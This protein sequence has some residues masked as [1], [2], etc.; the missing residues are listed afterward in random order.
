MS[1]RALQARPTLRSIGVN[2]PHSLM[3]TAPR[4]GVATDAEAE[5]LFGVLLKD[6]AADPETTAQ[7]RRG[8]GS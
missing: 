3:P 1:R 4:G 7:L 5:Q 2:A 6:G 8:A